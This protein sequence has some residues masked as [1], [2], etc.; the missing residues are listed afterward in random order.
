MLKVAY[1]RTAW[2][3]VAN[4]IFPPPTILELA[5]SRDGMIYNITDQSPYASPFNVAEI[6]GYDHSSIADTLEV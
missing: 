6:T 4:C 1:F 5:P 2:Q 3:L